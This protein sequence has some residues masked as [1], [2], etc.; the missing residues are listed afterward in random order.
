MRLFKKMPSFNAVAPGQTAICNVPVG[1]SYH[2]FRIR[3]KAGATPT[4]ATEAVFGTDFS[5]IR[6]LV[7]GDVKWR[8]TGNELI[9]L[10]KYYGIYDSGFVD[11]VLQM[12][13]SRPWHR[14]AQAEDLTRLGT[15]DVQT[16]TL[17]I[18]LAAGAVNPQLTLYAVQGEPAP[19]G[20]HV[21]IRKFAF[22]AAAVGIREISELPR[23]PY[24]LLAAHM[25]TGNIADVEVEA[26]QR[27]VFQA[28]RQLAE[29]YY[30]ETQRLW[31]T[32]YFHID[33]SATDRLS[34][35]LPL[36]LRDFR[37][38]ANVTAAGS[39]PILLE[40]LENRQR[41]AA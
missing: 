24:A 2:Q 27:I 14:T 26:D 18:D 28:D 29:S 25:V 7:D 17:E 32:G 22:N 19:L 3:Y 20:D 31:Q 36:S 1:M 30:E 8:L 41:M 5:E 15:A 16:L 38:K 37:I 33:F 12:L 11:G 39:F 9:A 13:F 10:N 35:A 34:D 4:D 21:C 40:R 23:G 6:L